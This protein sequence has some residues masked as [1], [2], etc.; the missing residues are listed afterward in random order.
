MPDNS[1][2]V[3]ATAVSDAFLATQSDTRSGIPVPGGRA[4][5]TLD[6]P[7]VCFAH[8]NLDRAHLTGGK[9]GGATLSDALCAGPTC[10]V[11]TS[12]ERT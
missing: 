11:L 7:Q 6:I 8:S 4:L 12:A 5:E 10:Q 9:L 1:R 2:R 3:G